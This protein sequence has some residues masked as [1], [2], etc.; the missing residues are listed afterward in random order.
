MKRDMVLIGGGGHAKVVIDAVKNS[1]RYEICGIVDPKLPQGT[2]VLGIKVLGGDGILRGI[3]KKGIENAFIGIGSI[4]DCSLRKKIYGDLKRIGFRLPFIAHQKAVIAEDAEIGEG[5]FVAAGAII[6]PGTTIGRN[7]IINTSSSVD[8]DCTIGDFVHIAP[9]VILS[10]GV[11]VGEE[12]HIGTGAKVTQYVTIGKRCTIGAGQTIRHDMVDGQ[13]SYSQAAGR[14]KKNRHVF[15]IAEAGVNHNGSLDIAKRIVDEAARAGADAV[16]FQTFKADG[17]ATAG[18]P[19]ARYQRGAIHGTR[20]QRAMLRKLELDEQCHRELIRHCRRRGIEFISSPFDMDS[21]DM[22][23]SLGLKIIKIPSGEITNY[24][25]LKRVGSLNKKLIISTGMSD[26]REVAAA[27]RVVTKAGTLEEDI[28]VMHCTTEYPAPFDHVNLQAMVA[29]KKDLGV[30]TGYSDHTSCT[31]VAIAAAA[32][33]ARAIEKHLTLDRSMKG[34]DHKASLEPREFGAMVR[35]IRN[36]EKAMGYGLKK[37]MPSEL[38]NRAVVRKSIVAG[39]DIERGELY[40]EDNLAA[41]RPGTGISPM[42]WG[43][44]LGLRAK[45]SFKKDAL[46]KL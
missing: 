30:E 22:L 4:S 40:T 42:R 37:A 23:V 21:V 24:P 35:S 36:I 25:Y 20:S 33:G 3:F 11:R 7:A 18:A 38:H 2:S 6:N 32:L 28:T 43:A 13:K 8:H 26:L 27:I 41:K 10:G 34:P 44:V 5:T 17:L 46:I 19:C 16:K 29:M 31:E 12:T 1:D 15:I 39:R 14:M 45:R 9:G